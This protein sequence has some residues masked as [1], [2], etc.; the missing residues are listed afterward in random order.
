MLTSEY[1]D[2]EHY[3]NIDVKGRVIIPAKFRE[4]L[5]DSFFVSKGL[6]ESI[7]IYSAGEWETFK[8]KIAALPSAAARKL[9][10]F[11]FPGSS[12]VEPDAQGRILI[13]SA[14]REYARLTKDLVVLG[15]SNH[16]EIWDKQRWTEYTS[17]PS[18]SAEEIAKT[19]EE[20]GV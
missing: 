10:L 4:S 19:M 1:Y 13:P 15:V 20:L 14:L 8:N 9:S 11:F 16:I 3:H 17:D 2:G 6:N 18:F 7:S 12:Q 5:G